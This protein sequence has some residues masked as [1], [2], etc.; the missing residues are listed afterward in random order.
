MKPKRE[1]EKGGEK[2]NE[3]LSLKDGKTETDL[4]CCCAI[5]RKRELLNR[6][7]KQTRELIVLLCVKTKDQNLK[8]GS[9]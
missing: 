3:S 7:G 4:F 5:L 2:R 9:G 6:K 8:E 1:T